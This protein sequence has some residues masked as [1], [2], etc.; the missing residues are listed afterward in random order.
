M[1]LKKHFN[2]AK[3]FGAIYVVAFLVYLFYGLQPAEATPIQADAT[4]E[5][6]SINLDIPVA[7]VQLVDHELE[8]PDTIVG[9]FSNHHNKTLLFG[10]STTAFSELKSIN[11]DD[12]IYYNGEIYQVTQIDTLEKKDINMDEILSE[13]PKDTLI[14]M[15][16]AGELLDGG[17]A[18]HRLI[19][20]AIKLS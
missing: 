5:I 17:D 1:E 2:L 9:S 19:I 13:S 3:V 16:C 6:P 14:L 4:L 18:T 20:E 8:T 15:T 7:K 10:H 12:S 11:I